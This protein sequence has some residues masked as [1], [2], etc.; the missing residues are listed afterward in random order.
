MEYTDYTP[1]WAN[2]ELEYNWVAIDERGT[3]YKF[4]NQPKPTITVLFG[5]IWRYNYGVEDSALIGKI[6][7]PTDFTK[8]I[9]ERPQT[10]TP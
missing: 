8:C 9:Y 5:G 3:I 10:E 4:K 2:I 6:T 7:P 1:D